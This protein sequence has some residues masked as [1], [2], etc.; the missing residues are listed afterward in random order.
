MKI[1][2]L[3]PIVFPAALALLVIAFFF[4]SYYRTEENELAIPERYVSAG[5][6]REGLARVA[7]ESYS[8]NPVS[9]WSL[10]KGISS[11]IARCP[12]FAYID[13]TGREVIPVNSKDNWIPHSGSFEKFDFHEGLVLV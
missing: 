8:V 1:A 12:R 13:K 4:G 6:F 5:N 7:K 11:V 10:K 9:Q 2:R 3:R